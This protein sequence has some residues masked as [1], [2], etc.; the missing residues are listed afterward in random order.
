M[1]TDSLRGNVRVVT[2]VFA[3]AAL[4]YAAGAWSGLLELGLMDRII[5]G[6]PV[7]ESE[8]T[9]N[10]GRQ[11]LIGGVSLLVWLVAGIAFISW[12]YGAYRQIDT[13]APGVRRFGHGWAIGSWFIPFFN[14]VRPKSVVNDVWRAGGKDKV[15]AQPGGVLLTWWTLFLLQWLLSISARGYSDASTAEGLRTGTLIGV[16]GD[17][18]AIAGALFAILVVRMTTDR[19]EARA[20]A[21]VAPPPP[22]GPLTAP[23]RPAGAAV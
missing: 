9:S 10:D 16:I 3:V 20:A 11:Q 2:V 6:E 5:A 7:T 18:V 12:L 1:L 21:A 14:L 8:V 23:E 19:L 15:D 17:G 4:V 22:E 13:I